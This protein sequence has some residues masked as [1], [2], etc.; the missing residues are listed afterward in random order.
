MTK[1]T[2]D[3]LPRTIPGVLRATAGRL[4]DK[5]AI[6]GEDG[7]KL[8]YAQLYE[9]CRRAAGSFLAYGLRHGD[10]IG[11]WAPNITNWI[12][13][14]IGAQLAGGV[15]VPINTRLK[16]REAAFIIN[17]SGLRLLFT[18]RDFL[19]IDYPAL[20]ANE[21]L[22]ALERI[23]MLEGGGDGVE[24]WGDFMARGKDVA[25]ADIDAALDRLTGDDLCDIMF[26]SGTTGRPMAWITAHAP[27]V[28][29]FF[30]WGDT[31]GLTSD[32]R[33]LVVNPFF[34]TF[35]YKAGWL[36]CLIM[37]ATILPHAVFDADCADPPHRP[38]PRHRAA[39]P[40]DPLSIDAVQRCAARG[41]SVVAAPGRHRRG[42]GA[43]RDDR[44]DAY[45]ARLQIRADRL[46]AD[47]DQRHRQ[48]L[49]RRRQRRARVADQRPSDA[50]GRGAQRRRRRQ[51][52]AARRARGN[53][54]ARLQRDDG[55]F[56]RSR[57]DRGSDH[58]SD[59]WLKTGDIG[60]IDS[61]G[62]IRITDRKKDMF[63]VGGFNCYPAEIEELML[64]HPAIAQVAVVGVPDERMGEVAKAF[65]IPRPGQSVPES[66][67]IAWSR[68]AMAN[69]KVPRSI[70]FVDTLPM[71]ASGKV[72]RFALRAD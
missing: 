61:E 19:G 12:V 27:T 48:Y 68:K 49:R 37:G 69:Y 42:V 28:R 4:P 6:E 50:G 52:R 70:E 14:A 17:R 53:P 40:A 7:A 72:Q 10:R 3:S 57:G 15:V 5:S 22:P 65:V 66:D 11:I 26:T 60:I 24:T 41:R 63:I 30:T 55:L 56:R 34:H 33:Y 1:I 9:A 71:T 21:D 38:R 59:G 62:Y 54:G 35:G 31:V 51:R 20:L 23:V 45:R 44:A 29:T 46:R 47:R 13:A 36:A 39:G 25:A 67:L 8:T 43:P 32:D 58:D 16:G 18:V 2:V 64:E